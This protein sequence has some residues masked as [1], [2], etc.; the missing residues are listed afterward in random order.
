MSEI[1][2]KPLSE[3]K[4]QDKMFSPLVIAIH[5]AKPC[6]FFMGFL[7]IES[8]FSGQRFWITAW[9]LWLLGE[10]TNQESF[11]FLSSFSQI[12]PSFCYC[13][14]TLHAGTW[15]KFC[16]ENPSLGTG[17]FL[18][19]FLFYFWGESASGQGQKSRGRETED[20]KWGL[21]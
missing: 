17:L 8:K 5:H 13:L 2:Q 10:K 9:N 18:F 19:L 20:L 11:F 15:Q 3:R 1:S 7:S 12:T 21:G 14:P 6:G 4:E 16:W